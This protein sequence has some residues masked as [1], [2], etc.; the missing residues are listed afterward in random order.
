VNNPKGNENKQLSLSKEQVDSV[1]AL[2]S[3]GKMEEAIITIK[4]LN[5][6]FPNVPLLFNIL[7]ACYKTLGQLEASIKMFE[8]A[9][10]IKPDYAEAHFNLAVILRELGQL[11]A[12]VK[13]YEK[14]IAIKPD[15]AEAH[16]N[17]G[18][19]L[20]ML[21]Q[22]VAA[23]RCYEKALAIKPDYAEAHNNLG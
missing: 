8:R 7:G 16:N 11:D 21:G 18:I 2:Y 20:N 5:E 6:D 3:S 10:A 12:A 15:Y 19:L 13:S 17:F 9:V 22:L 14:A 4:A 1:I 23:M